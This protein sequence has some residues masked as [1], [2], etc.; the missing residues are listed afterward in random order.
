MCF[1][2]CAPANIDQRCVL[3]GLCYVHDAIGKGL[4]IPAQEELIWIIG[5]VV[6]AS[7][8]YED[9]YM[10]NHLYAKYFELADLMNFYN[11]KNYPNIENM[12]NDMALKQLNERERQLLK[13]LDYNLSIK[14]DLLQHRVRNFCEMLSEH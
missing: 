6:I 4:E 12:K 9:S 13:I 5:A 7:K 3:I 10:P 1:K 8:M 14:M 11:Y 2:A